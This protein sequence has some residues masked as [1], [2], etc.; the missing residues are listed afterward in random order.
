MA[1][2]DLGPGLEL[3]RS[4][5]SV[6][7]ALQSVSRGMTRRLGLSGAERV[8]LRILMTQGPMTAGGL[9]RMLHLDPSSLTPL[10]QRMERHGFIARVRDAADARRQSI[11]VTPEGRQRLSHMSGTAES[12]MQAVV[13]KLDPAELSVAMRV[14][15][16]VRTELDA[17]RA[18]WDSAEPIPETRLAASDAA[19]TRGPRTGRRA[20]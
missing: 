15:Q 18:E 10:L 13:S 8:A 16:A 11:A 19:T 14:L 2:T 17:T 1:T 6:D 4:I 12:A 9:A 20:P 3:L 7:H 5:W